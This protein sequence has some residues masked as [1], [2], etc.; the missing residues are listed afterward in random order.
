VGYTTN[1]GQSGKSPNVAMG[2]W[3]NH[4]TIAGGIS[5]SSHVTDYQRV[6]QSI[7]I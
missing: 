3:E 4:G 2:K 6:L 1:L 7:R 5:E